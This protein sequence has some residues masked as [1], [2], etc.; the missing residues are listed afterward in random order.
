MRP[1]TALPTLGVIVAISGGVW[2]YAQQQKTSSPMLSP[3]DY[4]EIQ[5]LYGYY[6]SAAPPAS[7]LACRSGFRAGRLVAVCA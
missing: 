7:W 6:T 2:V 3:Q 4:L 1:L 5:Q